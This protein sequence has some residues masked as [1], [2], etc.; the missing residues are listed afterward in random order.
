M[1]DT[2]YL[3]WP[4]LETRHRDL[5]LSLDAWATATTAF[6]ALGDEALTGG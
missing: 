1:A 4:F 3:K 6:L 5:A 2:N